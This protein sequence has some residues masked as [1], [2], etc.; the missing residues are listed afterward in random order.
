[1]A[2]EWDFD[3]PIGRNGPYEQLYHY[4]SD[5][6]QMLEQQSIAAQKLEQ[7]HHDTMMRLAAALAMSGVE[8]A[9]EMYGVAVLSA[10]MA[11]ELQMDDPF[12]N[13]IYAAALVRNIGLLGTPTLRCNRSSDELATAP[14]SYFDHPALGAA[15]LHGGDSP[16]LKMA[17]DVAMAHHENYDGSGFPSGLSGEGIPLAAR[18][19]SAVQWTVQLIKRQSRLPVG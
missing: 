18:I 5:L 8:E 13:R 7:S 2:E 3:G 9:D 10:L 17:H 4:A 6:K 19:V 15:L 16:C 12:C 1:M 14:L 11:R